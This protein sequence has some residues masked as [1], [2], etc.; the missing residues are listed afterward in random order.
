[1]VSLLRTIRVSNHALLFPKSGGRRPCVGLNG[2][3]GGSVLGQDTL[4]L[5]PAVEE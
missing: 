4:M 3:D 2:L 5:S 1:M